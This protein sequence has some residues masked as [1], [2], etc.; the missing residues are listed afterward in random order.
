[1]AQQSFHG[2]SSK[3]SLQHHEA[4]QP[5]DMARITGIEEAGSAAVETR[6]AGS[7]EASTQRP[8]RGELVLQRGAEIAVAWI[9]RAV[10]QRCR[11]GG[12]VVRA[13]GVQ[14]QAPRIAQRERGIQLQVTGAPSQRSLE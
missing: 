3:I 14:R 4:A 9:A 6:V 5:A 2:T 12:G 7:G 10:G 1:L 8:V 13:A 11:Q